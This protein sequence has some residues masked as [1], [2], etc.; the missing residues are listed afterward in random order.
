M[1]AFAAYAPGK[2]ILLGE[3]AVVY[4]YPAIAV[5]VNQV[6]ARAT[7][8]A[9]LKAPTGRFWIEAP[10]VDLDC[11]LQDLPERHPLHRLVQVVQ[12][13]FGIAR[14]PALRLRIKS[15][16]PVAAGLGSG[17]AVSAAAIQALAAFLGRPLT[18]GQV[19]N[20]TFEVEKFLHGNP[21]G[22]DNT[23]VA[24]AQPV[25][26]VRDQPMEF[27][28]IKEP[29][30]LVIGDTGISSSTANVVSYVRQCWSSH[31]AYYESVFESI[32]SLVKK[33]R[34]L[35]EN[36]PVMEIG[37]LMNEN[38]AQLQKLG[39]SSQ[40][41]D[42]LVEAAR[43]VG[44]F[45]AKLSGGGQGGNMIALAAAGQE[46]KIASALRSAGAK[47]TIITTVR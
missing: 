37:P 18:K 39:V 13:H 17:A 3:H 35:I 36:G 34:T 29:F 33:A 41:L 19:S 7:V 6:E 1:P 23:V 5:P 4:G 43:K 42:H 9:D 12:D 32:G 25:F 47:H 20:L 46:E 11:D 38:H 16:I 40:E 44:A 2:A 27:L 28:S 8:Q 24:F 22:V 26:F 10:D 45:G 21:S 31:Q 14:F 30:S 15:T